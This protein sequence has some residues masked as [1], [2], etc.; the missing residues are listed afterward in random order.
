MLHKKI[1]IGLALV[2]FLASM[3]S[4]VFAGGTSFNIIVPKFGRYSST[5]QTQ[6]SYSYNIQYATFSSLTVGQNKT[7]Y[8]NAYIPG[9]TTPNLPGTTGYV[10]NLPYSSNLPQGLPVT[11]RVSTLWS[12]TVNVQVTGY[13]DSH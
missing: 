9:A 6:K 10:I 7:M 11:G 8:F 4:T 13:F 12:E 3:A 2:T 1:L 5:P